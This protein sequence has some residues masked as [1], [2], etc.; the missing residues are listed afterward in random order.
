MFFPLNHYRYF[1]SRCLLTAIAMC[2]LSLPA[3]LVRPT[4][5]QVMPDNTLGAEASEVMQNA[6]NSNDLITGGARRSQNLFHSFEAFNV[7]VNRGVFFVS[8]DGVNNIFS[9]I[10]GNTS[11]NIMGTLGTISSDAS[12][13]GNANL[14][15]IN[16]NGII[17]GPT[18]RLDVGRS[19]A[20]VTSD[21]IQFGDRGLFSAIDS[22]APSAL[23]TINP[24]AFLFSNRP[25][26]DIRSTAVMPSGPN[27]SLGIALGLRV[28]DEHSLILLGGDVTLDGQFSIG[29]SGLNAFGGRIELGGLADAG[30]VGLTVEN[31]T[32][33][34]LAFPQTTARA[35]IVLNNQARANTVG[36]G[37]GDIVIHGRT[38]DLLGNSSLTTG[39]GFGLGQGDRQGGDIRI[40]ATDSIRLSG[41]STIESTTKGEGDAGNISLDAGNVVSLTDGASI[42]ANSFSRGNAGQVIVQAGDSVLIEGSSRVTNSSILSS[43]WPIQ[44]PIEESQMPDT[45]QAG[46]VQIE[47]G[48][49]ALRN[50]GTIQSNVEAGAEGKGGNI[51]LLADSVLLDGGQLQTLL[52]GGRVNAASGTA[53]NITIEATGPVV[54][55]GDATTTGALISAVDLNAVGNGGSITV[56]ADS[57]SVM[58]GGAIDVRTRGVGDSG[59]ILL[60]IANRAEFDGTTPD[61]QAASGAFTRVNSRAVGN[62]GSIEIRAGSLSLINGAVLNAETSGTGD[63]GRIVLNIDDAL[64]IRGTT[65]DAQA[66]SGITNRVRGGVGNGGDIQI[67]AGS[68]AVRNGAVI[69]SRT[70]GMGNA[71]SLV[72]R[73][74]GSAEVEG[75]TPNSQQVSGI[76]SVVDSGAIGRGGPIDLRARRL[77]IA[78]GARIT[79]ETFGEGRAGDISLQIEGEARLNGTASNGQFASGVFS[80]V[81]SEAVGN[82]GN[83]RITAPTLEVGNGAILN[84][85]TDGQGRAGN[86]TVNAFDDVTLNT[87]GELSVET[88][89]TGQAGTILINTP[90]LTLAS[91][92]AITATATETADPDSQGGNIFLNVSTMD[93][94]GRVGVFSETQGQAPA[95]NLVLQPYSSDPDLDI[96]LRNFARVS[97][98]TRAEGQGGNL[99]ISAPS[100]INIQGIGDN[101]GRIAVETTGAG[102]AGT[103]SIETG[104]LRIQDGVVVSA[105]SGRRPDATGNAGAIDIDVDTLTLQD[106]SITVRSFGDSSAGNL[107][108]EA[109]DINV[110]DR[111]RLSA[112]T[113]A[114]KGGNIVLENL[115]TIELQANSLIS[116]STIDG[117]AGRI[118]INPNQRTADNLQLNNSRIET[119]A[120]GNGNA[121]GI[122]LNIRSIMMTNGSRMSASTASG[123]GGNVILRGLETLAL[124]GSEISAK[125]EIGRAGNLDIVASDEI[126]LNAGSILSV[127]AAAQ[128]SA[129]SAT[130]IAQ[131]RR[132]QSSRDRHSQTV[133]LRTNTF[134]RIAGTLTLSTDSLQVLNGSTIKVSS[135]DGLAGNVVIDANDIR[136]SRGEISAETGRSPEIGEDSANVTLNGVAL[137]VIQDS[138]LIEA[139][140]NALANGGNISINAS[141]GFITA[142]PNGNNDVIATAFA[143]TGGSLNISA[144]LLSGLRESIGA[145]GTLQAN[146]SNDMSV[147]STLGTDGVIVVNDLGIDPVQA[148]ADLPV[149]TASPPLSQGCTPGGGR[150][151]FR[152]IGQGGIPLGPGDVRGSDRAWEDISPPDH[153]ANRSIT[154]AQTW[155]VND[156]GQMV[157]Q[158]NLNTQAL[159]LTCHSFKKRQ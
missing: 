25:A 7:E 32:T 121:G 130:N 98:S 102:D 118:V 53:G 22:A 83:I 82:G 89:G 136:L 12:T 2:G 88:N 81:N 137:L 80:A 55:D 69:D 126:V 140:A 86:V 66:I 128:P 3:P 59:S 109:R 96:T 114:G 27:P 117:T 141:E 42:S 35:D 120:S 111:A 127:E 70:S 106:G 28:P 68:L 52:R 108:V 21:G 37:G 43:L 159:Q 107:Q 139:Q 58:K 91:D 17:F 23:L 60:Q 146:Q 142:S 94:S 154:E 71:G 84:A 122:Q 63:S 56:N 152:D 54:I 16:P 5:A 9:R 135:P 104:N 33:L 45:R 92:A 62:G 97:A 103:L 44:R 153:P 6:D 26:G 85:R 93:L 90:L 51:T 57:L 99:N 74:R 124:D 112:E 133:L 100:S 123:Q 76:A 151:E 46:G 67:E 8:P 144:Q 131:S 48:A 36:S 158:P 11:S 73:I 24:T 20:A 101:P 147:S 19:F 156:Q 29:F 143:G 72:F 4:L 31:E 30:A 134:P 1:H 18:A 95:G 105:R 155:I 110:F 150:G 40:D 125:T 115:E 41:S 75:T 64:E 34:S 149:E 138:S 119:A 148:A 38:M 14:F 145:S 79:A 13:R 47:T 113:N 61:G 87:N 50:G 77:A 15:L 129:S 157:L 132:V 78:N 65:P 10:T 49:I 39:I 116:A